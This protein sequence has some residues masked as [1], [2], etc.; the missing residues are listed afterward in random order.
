MAV[1]LNTSSGLLTTDAFGRVPVA[2]LSAKRG[3][4][5]YLEVVPDAPLPE[6][7]TGIFAARAK[8]NY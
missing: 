7:T 8:G 2:S 5:M 1:Y 6:G 3:D 4:L